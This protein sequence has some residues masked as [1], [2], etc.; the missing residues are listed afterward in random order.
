[1]GRACRGSVALCEG[2]FY[3]YM[4]IDVYS[5][6]V[7]GWEVHTEERSKLAAELVQKAIHDEGADPTRLVLHADNGGP[8]KGSTMLATL[9]RLGV[10][11]SFSQPSVSDD[12]HV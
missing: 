1:M 2:F 6:R 7:V 9:Q 11:A 5:R 4:I 10:V 8:T 12:N 3:M